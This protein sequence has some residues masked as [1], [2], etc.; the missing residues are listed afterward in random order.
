V[1]SNAEGVLRDV[2]GLDDFRPGQADVVAAMLAG[3]DVL[4]V[5]PPGSGKSISY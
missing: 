2:F 4:S 1:T 3:R 5:A